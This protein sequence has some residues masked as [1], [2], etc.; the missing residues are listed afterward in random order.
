VTTRPWAY[1]RGIFSVG[2]N[3]VL[4]YQ[5]LITIVGVT[6]GGVLLGMQVVEVV[7]CEFELR[8]LTRY[9]KALIET[10]CASAA[11]VLLPGYR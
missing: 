10:R 9:H 1:H 4:V 7:E 8:N 2:A 3:T 6:A 5:Y 11:G